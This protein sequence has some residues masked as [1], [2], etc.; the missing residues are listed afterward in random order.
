[1]QTYIVLAKLTEKGIQNIKNAP[2]RI[3]Q[4]AKDIKAMGGNMVAFYSVMG[5]YDYVAVFEAKSDEDIMRFL[6]E[7]GKGGSVRTTTLRAFDR[8]E[9]ATIVNKLA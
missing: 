8:K 2:N 7:L 1:M 5:E 6:M 4:S 3:E 9:M